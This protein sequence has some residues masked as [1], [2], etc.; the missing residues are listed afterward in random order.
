MTDTKTAPVRGIALLRKDLNA[1]IDK[2]NQLP[3]SLAE[4]ASWVGLDIWD[5]RINF[6][7]D[8]VEE[9]RRVVGAMKREGFKL[10]VEKPGGSADSLW[11]VFHLGDEWKVKVFSYLPKTCKVVKRTRVLPAQE[12]R[13]IEVSEVICEE[14]LEA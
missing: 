2:V 10:E 5:R 13:T 7:P 14:T 12:E 6:M 1:A 11:A 8:S 9:A 4:F 3:A